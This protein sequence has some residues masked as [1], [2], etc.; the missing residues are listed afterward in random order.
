MN[1][2][3]RIVVILL[4]AV[5]FIG[6]VLILL[7]TFG[8]VTPQQLLPAGTANTVLGQWIEA[9]ARMQPNVTLLTTVIAVLVILVSLW[10]LY[11]ELRPK[12]Q[13]D[14]IRI[15]EDGLG[16]VTVRTKS[17]HDLILHTASTM[18]D[19]LQVH[20]RID[21]GPGE[22]NIHCRTSLTPEA[23][24]PQVTTELQ[25]R[26]KQAVERYLGMHVASVTVDAQ[27]EPLSDVPTQTAPTPARR[28]LR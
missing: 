26:I 28:Q 3:N 21:R 13:P 6:A 24:V 18:P 16:T 10:I 17:V 8:A 23:D 9:F 12:P 14:V 15:R 11:L 27:L 25:E 22:V 2:F 1:V 19:V 7:I 5:L 20:A 4:A